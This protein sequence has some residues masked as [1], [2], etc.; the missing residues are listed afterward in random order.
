MTYTIDWSSRAVRARLTKAKRFCSRLS[1][2]VGPTT[3]KSVKALFLSCCLTGSVM[4]AD[5]RPPTVSMVQLL[6]NPESFNDRRVAVG[7]FL[8]LQY[9][10]SA[11]Y[12]HADDF[13]HQL[14]KNALWAFIPK[15]QANRECFDGKYVVVIGTVRSNYF[16]HM[17]AY[18][19]SIEVERLFSAGP[20]EPGC[21]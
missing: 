5:A 19:G 10:G 9:E 4:A 15:S 17:G 8:S 7:G 21:I 20:P 14:R 3:M 6:A 11:L 1:R 18:S 16:G 12:L 2:N 13:E